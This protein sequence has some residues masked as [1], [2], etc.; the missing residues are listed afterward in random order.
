VMA[1]EWAPLGIRVNCVAPGYVRT[2]MIEALEAKG[3]LDTRALAGR[4]LQRRLGTPQDIAGA[5]L[6]L[7]GEG[8]GFVTG[9]V[10][11]VDGGWDAYG[12]V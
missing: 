8:A 1:I 4:A 12:Y 6:Y 9:T 5:V 11:T 10:L 2:E 3:I 7:A